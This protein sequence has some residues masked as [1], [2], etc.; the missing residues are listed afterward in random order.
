MSTVRERKLADTAAHMHTD[1]QRKVC[2]FLYTGTLAPIIDKGSTLDGPAGVVSA[3]IRQ[4]ALLSRYALVCKTWHEELQIYRQEQTDALVAQFIELSPVEALELINISNYDPE[5]WTVAPDMSVLSFEVLLGSRMQFAISLTRRVKDSAKAAQELLVQCS[6]GGRTDGMPWLSPEL[7]VQPHE[8]CNKSGWD[9]QDE[10]DG[11][12]DTWYEAT[13]M[14]LHGWLKGHFEA[15][16][17]RF[18]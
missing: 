8:L 10:D 14:Q 5:D 6:V 9:F 7:C 2:Q 16:T 12:Y 1:A 13:R 11:I 15:L 17:A 3:A 4:P 18:E